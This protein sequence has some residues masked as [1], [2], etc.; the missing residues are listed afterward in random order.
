MNLVL[1]LY[2]QMKNTQKEELTMQ[3]N[4]HTGQ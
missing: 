1:T 4:G 2:I 3:N